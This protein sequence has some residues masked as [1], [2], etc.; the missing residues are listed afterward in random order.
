M[1][2]LLA[3]SPLAR[4]AGTKDCAAW[5]C[6]A[7][8]VREQPAQGLVRLQLLHDDEAIRA[9]VAAQ[10]GVALPSPGVLEGNDH[11][12]CAWIA[13]AEWLWLMADHAAPQIAAALDAV[14]GSQGAITLINDSRICVQVQGSAARAL[15]AKG[16][17]LDFHPQG[18]QSGRCTTTRFAQIAVMLARFDD[19]PTFNLYA[20]R[21]Q[22]AYLWR[23]LLDA[24]AEF[25]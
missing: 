9:A 11:L 6:A 19:T 10:L 4:F 18:F 5:T 21:S 24:A 14:C 2:S 16:S 1:V 17:G 3:R 7:V 25:V 15:L 23:W 12:R 13:P 8:S 22:A 20:D